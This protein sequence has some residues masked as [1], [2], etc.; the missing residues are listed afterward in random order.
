MFQTMRKRLTLTV[1]LAT[2]VLA[3]GC[4][5]N[6]A[7]RGA[8]RGAVTLDGQ[9]LEEGSILFTPME[10]TQGITTGGQIEKGRYQL[11][12]AIG[13]A[14]GWNRVEIQAMRKT[15]KMLQKPLGPPGEMV[16]ERQSLVPA[17]FNSESTLKAEIK[18][19]DNV[20]DFPLSAKP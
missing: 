18:T 11:A 3:A 10:G 8:V 17:R 9:P 5:K 4:D 15:G 13:P 14:V 16:P 12:N 2:L 20:I 6:V 19:G 1:C 7:N